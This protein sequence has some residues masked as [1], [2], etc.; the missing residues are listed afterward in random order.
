[1]NPKTDM[2]H[3]LSYRMIDSPGDIA[4]LRKGSLYAFRKVD[5]ILILIDGSKKLDEQ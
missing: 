2:V 3:P 1:M 4:A 5:L